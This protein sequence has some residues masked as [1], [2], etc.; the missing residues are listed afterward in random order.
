MVQIPNPFSDHPLNVTRVLGEYTQDNAGPLLLIIAGM[1]GNEPS[2][3]LAFSRVQEQLQKS[4]LTFRGRLCGITGNLPALEKSIRF[5]D[6]DMNRMWSTDRIESL[7]AGREPHNVEEH[8]LLEVVKEIDARRSEHDRCFFMD[9]H[10]TSSASLPYV[11]V[12][13][14]AACARY[15]G[16]FV[17]FTVIGPGDL[18]VGSCDR[19]LIDQGMIGFTFEAGQHDSLASIEN[20]EAAIWLAMHRAGCLSECPEKHVALLAKS[21][22]DGHRYFD[23]EYVHQIDESFGFQMQP[24]Y[25]NF[26]RIRR[27]DLLGWENEV[28]ITSQ[29]DARIF[30]PRYQNLGNEGFTVIRELSGPVPHPH[31]HVE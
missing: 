8:E 25:Y 18:L 19:Y 21:L 9:C 2:A 4:R 26:Q 22:L 3:V 7:L 30:M 28:P 14:D 13:R 5:I 11:S 20:H 23:V 24:G 15:A 29:W 16:E 31:D 1:H 10:T 27:G 12:P 6:H 17:V